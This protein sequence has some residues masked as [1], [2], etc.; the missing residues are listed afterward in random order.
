MKNLMK[1]LGFV[2]TLALLLIV[3]QVLAQSGS[4]DLSWWTVDGGGGTLNGDG[5][6][7]GG[8]AGQ[9]DAGVL[10]GRGYTLNG[11]FWGGVTH[12]DHATPTA[13][14]S[15][16]PL[17]GTVPL[18]VT[19]SDQ[20]TDD[21]VS[22]SWSFG[23][24]ITSTIQH[25]TH[26]YT[27]T[28]V[29]TVALTVDGPEGTDTLTR[30]NYIT[31]GYP[32]PVTAF[33]ATPLTGTA[34]LTVTFNDQSTGPIVS[35]SW[36]F[37]DGATS[38]A[39]HPVHV[40][41][42]TGTYAI[43]LTVSGPGGS[44]TETKAGY[45]TVGISPPVAH[46]NFIRWDHTPY[47]DPPM[48]G[49]DKVYFDG[50][51]YDTDEGG[52]YVTTYEWR[53]DLDGWLSDQPRF[54]IQ[55]SALSSGTHTISL[56][57]Q[58]DEGEWS[59]EAVQALTVQANPV[60]DTRTLILVNRQKLVS[61]YSEVEASDVM[62]KLDL[63]AAHDSVQGVVVQ[64]ENDSA[65]AAA[66]AAWDA[67]PT[68]T[69]EANGV[70]EAIKALVDA[71]W[72]AYADLEYLVIVGDDRAIPF[73]RVHDQT[74]YPESNYH[75][76][77]PASTTGAALGDGMT[78]SD[79]YYA[80]AVPTVPGGSR[81]DGHDLY[82]PDLGAGRL[83]E[84]PAEIAAQVDA[85]LADDG[86]V[87]NDTIV[88][89]YDFIRDGAQAMCRELR[90]D[91][92][93]TDCTLIGEYWNRSDFIAGVLNVRHDI[94]SVNGHA[95]HYVIGTPSD[96]I[97]ASDVS[98]ATADHTR[99]LFYTVGC[100]SGLNVPP[101]NPYED[102]DTAQALIQH[103]AN[104]VANTG[105]GWGYITS[106]GLSEQLMLDFTER[107]VYGQSATVG[108]ALA[109]AKQE[110]YLNERF[111]DY[112]DEKI[113][114]ES[115]LYGLPMVRYTTSTAAKSQSHQKAAVV[116]DGSMRALQDGLTVN[117][118]SYQFPALIAESTADG[119]YYAF[120]DLV[121]AS[122][123]EP[124]QPKYTADISFPETEAH[125]V[126]FRGGAYTDIVS[127]NPVVDQAITETV[128]LTEPVFSAQGWY[129]P[130][131]H[132]FNHLER[133]TSADDKLVTL[134]AQFNSQSQ[135]E[136]LYDQLSFDIYYH[137][138]SDDRT[139][140]SIM[141]M[142]SELAAGNAPV[143]IIATDLSGIEAVVIAYTDGQGTW[144]SVS[145]TENAG[146]WSGSFPA[147]T[148]TKFFIQAVD[149]A[150][151]VSADDNNGLYFEP[152]DIVDPPGGDHNIYL[153]LVTRSP[154]LLCGSPR[155]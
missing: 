65:V 133:T 113:M 95:N 7:L 124:I 151:N 77:S 52:W 48:Q 122:D 50:S 141:S 116:Q 57:C 88:T 17:S 87:A 2:L 44:D 137:V 46:I 24:G 3:S 92:I 154:T 39:R 45:V 70:A 144:D 107:L 118:L 18:T 28:G 102:L 111:F 139:P 110:Y 71:Q 114:I 135:T 85:F 21:I 140:P 72:A 104:Y 51:G 86:V 58:D 153:P 43:T 106:V 100:H 101:A 109:A 16:S 146:E 56:K 155:L 55:A 103:Q 96:A 112:Y 22:W 132:R 73:R 69:T 63:L 4:Y 134:L 84:T 128:I 37:G 108:Q 94:V 30:T 131:L 89:G 59:Q 35:W 14:F 41:E 10:E 26:S 27:H 80:D 32:A 79:D 78:L 152:G 115:T 119:L 68:S 90:N 74:R 149:K 15:G 75:L 125:G 42:N 31:V 67:D 93:A 150:G 5:Y 143:T 13:A 76:V 40:Y 81:W 117:S 12:T 138:D 147:P 82:I 61:L 19:F 129:P 53:S 91:G 8:T 36:D 142:N 136:R 64:V 49:L 83:I 121:H 47:P 38:G 66:Y 6:T 60:T 120:G 62:A 54:S 33:A 9:P 97:Y 23:D 145:L 98:G 148:S 130:L 20:S 127:F 29:F 99:A 123:G 105:Y 25:P 34:P 1:S 126:I 11:G